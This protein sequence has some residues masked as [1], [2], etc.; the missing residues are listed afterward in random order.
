MFDAVRNNKR[1][2]Q[3]FLVL[4]TLPFAFWGVD[5]YV[6]NTGAGN[7]IAKVGSV[8]ITQQQYQEAWRDQQQRL[9]QMMGASFDPAMPGPCFVFHQ[10]TVRTQHGATLH[11]TLG[12]EMEH[13]KAA[14]QG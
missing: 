6:H 4:I 13:Q 8:K 2:V 12:V 7:D 3:G 1:I 10:G 5:S 9:R 11:R 14:P